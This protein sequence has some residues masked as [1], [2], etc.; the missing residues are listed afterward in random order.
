MAATTTDYSAAGNG[1]CRGR[2][3]HFCKKIESMDTSNS[4]MSRYIYIYIH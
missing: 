2:G 1:G 4:N 3:S